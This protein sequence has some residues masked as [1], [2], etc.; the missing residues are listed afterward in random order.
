M[1][2]LVDAMKSYRGL[3]ISLL[4]IVFWRGLSCL[5]PPNKS[6]ICNQLNYLIIDPNTRVKRT[7]IVESLIFV[8]HG[9]THTIL[10]LKIDYH[11][12][13]WHVARLPPNSRNRCWVMQANTRTLCNVK[14][15]IDKHSTP[16]PMYKWLMKEC[17]FNNNVEY[18]F[19][20]LPWRRQTLCKWQ[21]KAICVGLAYS[22][23]HM[24]GEDR[25]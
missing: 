11:L 21:Q 15:I 12:F 19:W 16:T 9:A 4:G 22:S 14:G 2:L 5:D 18:E 24:A 6:L 7:C 3:K 25:Y 17:P 8:E 1:K 13:H 23:Q 20:F 10:V